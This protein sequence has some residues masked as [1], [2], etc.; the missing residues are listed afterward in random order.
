MN[1]SGA[2]HRM[3]EGNETR[4]FRALG[5]VM[6]FGFFSSGPCL[7]FDAELRFRKVEAAALYIR[8]DIGGSG[9]AV[10]K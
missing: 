7:I 10:L 6:C 3:E 9:S 5:K 1:V 4:N 8:S 2:D